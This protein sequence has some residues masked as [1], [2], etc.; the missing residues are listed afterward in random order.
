MRRARMGEFGNKWYSGIRSCLRG[1]TKRVYN[2]RFTGTISNTVCHWLGEPEQILDAW[3]AKLLVRNININ[4]KMM[5]QCSLFSYLL[6]TC[7]C[8]LDC[9]V[10]FQFSVYREMNCFLFSIVFFLCGVFSWWLVTLVILDWLLPCGS[11]L[12]HFSCVTCR[13]DDL[14]LCWYS[15]KMCSR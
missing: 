8:R 5:R 6:K 4:T 1:R 10:S 14:L 12:R 7:N 3:S 13:I 11:M 2:Q 9:V 15:K